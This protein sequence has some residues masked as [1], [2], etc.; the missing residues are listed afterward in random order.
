[1]RNIQPSIQSTGGHAAAF[2][3]VEQVRLDPGVVSAR[4]C[5]QHERVPSYMGLRLEL[6][7]F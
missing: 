7:V 5:P 1:M 2:S 3:L 6:T 4:A